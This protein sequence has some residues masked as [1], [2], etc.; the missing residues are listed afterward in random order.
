MMREKL[1]ANARPA[2]GK[3]L[4]MGATEWTMLL[5][6]SGLWGGSFFFIGVAVKQLPTLTIVALRVTLAALVLW[7]V[8]VVSGRKVPRG[9]RVWLAFLGMGLI[10]NV[11]PFVLIV[12]GQQTIA[13][14]LASILNATTP[15]FTVLVAGLL[16]S[17]E[18]LSL[19][20]LIG[21]AIGFG[22]VSVM[23]GWDAFAGLGKDVLAEAAILGGALAYAF[24]GVYGRRFKRLGVDP[25]ITATGQVSAAAL[26]LV[27]AALLVDTPWTLPMPSPGTWGALI[28]LAVLSTA[29]AYVLYFRI[30]ARAG[31]TN[32]LLVTFLIPVSAILL[33][34]LFLGERITW[35]EALGMAL[36]SLGLA[37][38]DGRLWPLIR[39][40]VIRPPA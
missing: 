6:L 14:G 25:I 27:P 19:C 7:G 15:L 35:I 33:G 30:L 29:L 36:I 24:A 11:I 9:A 18:R 5:V 10:N 2:S 17:D 28:G 38:M 20:K 8:I 31:A 13:S 23:I 40:R 4:S 32:V 34:T 26:L 12:W 22:G 37:V 1:P 21:V 39:A 3:A 16:L